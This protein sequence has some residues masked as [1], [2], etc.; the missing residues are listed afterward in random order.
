[1]SEVEDGA[2]E[3]ALK[4]WQQREQSYPLLAPLGQDLVSVQRHK[5]MSSVFFQY[6]ATCAHAKG[7]AQVNH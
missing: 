1:M 5:H 3:D 4:F 6:V 2:V 7:T